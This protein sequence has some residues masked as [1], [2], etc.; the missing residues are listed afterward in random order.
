MLIL[1][2]GLPGSGKTYFSKALASKLEALHI[3]SDSVRRGLNLMEK[4]DNNSKQVV[5]DKMVSLTKKGLLEHPYV[6]V[7]ATFYLEKI[8][9]VYLDIADSL[10]IPIRII[11]L[12]ANLETIKVRVT[13]KRPDS[14]ADFKVYQFL[15]KQ[16]EPIQE[17][18]LTLW[19][20]HLSL[21]E[22]IDKAKEYILIT[23]SPRDFPQGTSF[24]HESE[25][26]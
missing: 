11:E 25:P 6:I 4:Y 22:M 20:D 26:N 1:V 14:E 24:K 18:H 9:K 17:S 19:S 13:K 8:R 21:E 12:K 15:L 7:D 16:F 5:Y 2:S 23:K 10:S 3:N